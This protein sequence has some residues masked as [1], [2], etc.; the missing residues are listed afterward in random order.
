[1]ETG[2]GASEFLDLNEKRYP[3]L[4]KWVA[5]MKS[6]P[7][8]QRGMLVCGSGEASKELVRIMHSEEHKL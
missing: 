8:V 4:F 2:Y 3:N 7:A 6:R 1:V 5:R